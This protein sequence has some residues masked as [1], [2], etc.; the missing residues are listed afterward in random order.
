MSYIYL[1]SRISKLTN[2]ELWTM[3][4]NFPLDCEGEKEH[5]EYEYAREEFENRLKRIGFL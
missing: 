2:G 3:L 1:K 4:D 5:K